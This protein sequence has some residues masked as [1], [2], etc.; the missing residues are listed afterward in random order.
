[1]HLV[2]LALGSVAPARL[3]AS[4]AAPLAAP[5]GHSLGGERGS[6]GEREATGTEPG[7]G[8]G[9]FIT[10]VI[11]L[12]GAR[13]QG[14]P[15]PAA[16]C[17]TLRPVRGGRRRVPGAGVWR[18]EGMRRGRGRRSQ[19]ERSGTPTRGARA[20][21][22]RIPAASHA[23]T[24]ALGLEPTR[25]GIQLR[26]CSRVPRAATE[27]GGYSVEVSSRPL[28]LCRT[29][30]PRPSTLAGAGGRDPIS[31][32]LPEAPQAPLS[33]PGAG[34]SRGGESRRE[35]PRRAVLP[36]GTSPGRA[37]PLGKALVRR[38]W[39]EETVLVVMVALTDLL[40]S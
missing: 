26:A 15:S 36:R 21:G 11:S 22:P 7:A 27:T 4:G 38:L 29:P 18:R 5:G 34:D 30:A 33:L 1:M 16:L 23:P 17:T 8:T 20:P 25:R 14:F 3:R 24:A 19:V 12:R 9:I 31:R 6:R 40:R 28:R 13:L 10:P 35:S 32:L 2:G 39:L 37:A